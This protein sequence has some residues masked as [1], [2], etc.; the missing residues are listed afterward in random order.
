M[1]LPFP[2]RKTSALTSSSFPRNQ[3]PSQLKKSFNPGVLAIP[4]VRNVAEEPFTRDDFLLIDFVNEANTKPY[5]DFIKKISGRLACWEIHYLIRT[6]PSVY[7]STPAS[8]QETLKTIDTQYDEYELKYTHASFCDHSEF[9]VLVGKILM[10]FLDP[11]THLIAAQAKV[12]PINL[13]DYLAKHKALDSK[14]LSECSEV[15]INYYFDETDPKNWDFFERPNTSTPY[16][17]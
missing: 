16:P 15:H 3:Q 10:E 1:N 6:I 17:Y 2:K 14:P 12:V 5:G 7:F 4:A 11:N 9:Q 13:K 8:E